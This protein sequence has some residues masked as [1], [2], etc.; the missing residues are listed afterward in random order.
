[1]ERDSTILVTGANGFV[2]S[3]LVRY[4]ETA[5]YRSVFGL[6]SS[7]CDL[8]DRR[9]VKR[10]FQECRPYYVF[11]LAARVRGIMGNMNG[12][13]EGFL[14]NILINTHVVEACQEYRVKKVVALGTVAMYPNE[15][16]DPSI[17]F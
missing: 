16:K 14:Q 5:G 6:T 10:W 8:T 9:S 7:D 1:M 12:Q 15:P 11:H 17:G 3:N 4:L 13:G 2:G